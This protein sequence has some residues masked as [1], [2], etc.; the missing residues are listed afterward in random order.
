[1]D[2]KIGSRSGKAAAD[3]YILQMKNMSSLKNKRLFFLLLLIFVSI[4]VFGGLITSKSLHTKKQIREMFHMNKILQQ[5]GYYTAEFEFKMLGISYYLSKGEYKKFLAMLDRLYNQMKTRDGLIKL[6]SFASKDEEMNFYLNLQNPDTGAFMDSNYPVSSYTGPTSN[7]LEHLDEL[8]GE[9][10]RPLKLKYPLRYL[11]KICTPEKLK[12]YLD[13]VSTVGW[14]ASKLPQTTFH[15][16]RDILSLFFEESVVMK[17]N[18]YPVTPEFQQTMIK[19]FYDW[20]D[21]ETGLWGPKNKNGKLMKKDLS[22]TASIIKIFVNRGGK[23]I[24]SD[25]PLRYKDALCNSFLD[26]ALGSVPEDD[27]I[28]DWHEW[29]L[30]VPKT[31][32]T[33]TRFF[34]ND[35]SE[36]TKSRVKKLVQ[37]YIITSFDKFYVYNEGAFTNQPYGKHAVLDA[38]GTYSIFNEI[39]ALSYE[40]QIK[41]WGDREKTIRDLGVYE[42]TE[43]GKKDLE[44]IIKQKGINSFRIFPNNPDLTDMTA[45]ISAVFYSG[46]KSVLDIID[47]TPGMNNWLNTTEQSMGNWVSKDVVIKEMEAIKIKEVPVYENG[48]PAEVINGILKTNGELTIIGFDMLQIPVYKIRYVS[49]ITKF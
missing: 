35:I 16:A 26:E 43:L 11:D 5:E 27:D 19:W 40:K 4:S 31:I 15:N 8:A 22:N 45:E 42:I 10:K 24:Y 6:P 41:L 38:C 37:F 49:S 13:D 2:D 36:K 9:T 34:W 7:V 32:R 25:Y 14:P 23:D 12:L 17:H 44:L 18:L 33:F 21:A 29:Y 39:G 28:E 30:K 48:I 3:K 1:M 47:L 20:Q 46:K